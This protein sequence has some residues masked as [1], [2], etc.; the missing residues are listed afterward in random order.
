[1]SGVCVKDLQAGIKL[2]TDFY[3]SLIRGES[4]T[5]EDLMQVYYIEKEID[6]W[7]EELEK[8]RQTSYVTGARIS[9]GSKTSRISDKVAEVALRKAEIEEKIK[10][11][12]I[13]LEDVKNEVTMY[14]LAIDDPQTRLIFKLRCLNL[15]SWNEVADK[16]GGMNS[17]YSVKKRFYRYLDKCS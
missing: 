12:V 13:E 9:G 16:V 10:R 14:I 8:I 17:E 5:K 6:L 4:V 3:G 7:K 1:M 11:K 15:M 2:R